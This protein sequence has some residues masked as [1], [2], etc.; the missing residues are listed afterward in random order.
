MKYNWT[1]P[2]FD[3]YPQTEGETDV[4]FT[5]HYVYSADDGEGHTASVYGTV[6]VTFDPKEPFTPFANITEAMAVSWTIGALGKEQ[7]AA[8]KVN[9]DGQIANQ[10]NPPVVSLPP[11]WVVAEP[12]P[13]V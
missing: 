9:L 4:V 1:F 3:C 6:G 2:A 10:I 11:P 5:I 12:V 13:V 7:V 8:M